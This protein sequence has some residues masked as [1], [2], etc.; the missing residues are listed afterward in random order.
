[1]F[2]TQTDLIELGFAS[3][4]QPNTAKIRTW[5]VAGTSHADAF[6]VGKALSVLGCT[7]SVTDGPQHEVVQAAF[8]SFSRW[9]SG[10]RPPPSPP[11]FRFSKSNPATLSLNDHG[12][13]IGGVRTPA[14]DVPVS[15]LSGSASAGTSP[16]CSL[17]GSSTPCDP[18]L[19]H[20]L[21]PTKQDYLR[22]F[23]SSL[24]RAIQ[25]GFILRADRTSLRAK[26][27]VVPIS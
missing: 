14:V 1:M 3:A 25:A 2:E 5:E 15:T 26:A 4:Q 11:T 7:G 24:D 6:L 8:T 20:Q 10:G 16:I 27:Q 21:Y 17:F 12:N 18:S 22:R 23:Q 19:L 13:V 9:V